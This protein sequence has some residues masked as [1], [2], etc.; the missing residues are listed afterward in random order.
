VDSMI[1]LLEILARLLLLVDV[2]ASILGQSNIRT[3]LDE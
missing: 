2:P 3:R 1:E